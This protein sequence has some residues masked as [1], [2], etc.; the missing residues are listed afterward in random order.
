M[1]Q[2]TQTR[3]ASDDVSDVFGDAKSGE[4]SAQRDGVRGRAK[5]RALGIFSPRYFLLATV[6]LTVAMF[7]GG[8]VPFVSKLTSIVALFVASFAL[9]ALT[10]GSRILETATGG[11]VAAGLTLLLGNLT[12]LAIGGTTAAAVGLGTGFLVAG[13]GAYFGGD[14]RDGLTREL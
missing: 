1:T 6:L 2:R 13:L 12:L 11:M 9:G 3:E 4:Q 7:L 5:R 8:V 10:S 14:L